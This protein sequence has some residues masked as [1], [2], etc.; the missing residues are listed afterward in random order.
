MILIYFNC[1]TL[2][3]D[4]KYFLKLYQLYVTFKSYYPLLLST[5]QT[6][7]LYSNFAMTIVTIQKMTL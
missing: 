3:Y 4:K 1:I 2:K 5:A 6:L 7:L